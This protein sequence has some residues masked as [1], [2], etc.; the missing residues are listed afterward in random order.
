MFE[1]GIMPSIANVLYIIMITMA[2]FVV[3]SYNS[4]YAIISIIIVFVSA[5]CLLFLIECEFLALIFLIIYVGAIV[6]LFLFVIMMLDLKK[7][8]T[9]HTSNTKY[10]IFGTVVIISSLFFVKETVFFNYEVFSYSDDIVFNIS[11][12]K[13]YFVEDVLPE[14]MVIG[15]VLYIFY[16]V[17]FLLA[18]L[19]LSLTLFGVVYLAPKDSLDS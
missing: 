12:Y 5:A 4:L 10:F 16:S 8:A 1:I 19:I 15:Q 14:I 7:L 18:G 13:N 11:F 9:I 3:I 17:Q 2:S 6:V